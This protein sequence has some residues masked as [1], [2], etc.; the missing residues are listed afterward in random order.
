MLSSACLGWLFFAGALLWPDWRPLLAL[1][2]ILALYRAGLFIH[3]IT[4]AARTGIP[5]FQLVWNLVVG[6]PMLMPSF[7]YVGVHT[8]HHKRNIYGTA[9]DPEYLPL[10]RPPRRR[11]VRFLLEPL[12]IPA[13]VMLRFLVLSPVGLLLPRFHRW[14]ELRASSL[15]INL[16]FVRPE[17]SPGER[18]A[19][20]LQEGGMLLLWGT[21]VLLIVQGRL[22][23]ELIPLWYGVF[24]GAVFL[25][26]LR[27]LGAH[28]YLSTG[29]QMDVVGQLLDTVNVPGVF[30]TTLWAPVGLRFHALH[31]YLPSMPYHALGEA[32]RRLL[33]KLP[34]DAPYRQVN[35]TS[36]WAALWS[37]WRHAAAV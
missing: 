14:L 37:L 20:K 11:I 18:R 33:E 32:H 29:E 4:H 3:E 23:F 17:L 19:M 8:E 24:F 7:T 31:H 28:R 5:G 27:T 22:P 25:N 26:Q 34:P 10:G 6:L 35:A 13:V 1:L 36:L 16:A 30:W 9:R 2:A 15:V 12:F 21:A